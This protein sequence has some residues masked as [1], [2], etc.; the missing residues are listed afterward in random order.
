[1]GEGP[2]D[3]PEEPLLG[4][5]YD[6][7]WDADG[8]DDG[9][10]DEDGD[11]RYEDEAY[12]EEP[13]DEPEPRRSRRGRG[14]L[15]VLIVLA[16][17]VGAGW[18]GGRWAYDEISSRLAPAPDYD[19]PGS[20]TVLYQVRSGASSVQIGRG[21]KAKGVVKSVDAFSQAARENDKSRDIQVGYYQ[22]KKQMKASQALDLLVDPANLVQNLV[23]V[24]EGARVNQIVGTI[25]AKTD[26]SRRAVTSALANPRA[27]GLPAEAKGNP[28][29]FLFPATYTVP[30]K[31]TAVGLIKEMVSKSVAVE[32]DLGVTS[33]GSK[34]GF[35]AEQVLTV[36]SILEYE[37]NTSEDY[38]K[39]ARVLYNRLDKG[40]LLQLDSTVSYI[41]KRKGD[42]FTTAAERASPS[43]YNTYVHKGLPPGPIG[44]PGEET[45][46]AALAPAKGT[47]LFFVPDYENKSTTFSTTLAQHN[48]AVAKLKKYCRTHEEC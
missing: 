12:E 25:V 6:G 1:M 15:P 47:W 39:V 17:L 44:S 29:G 31:Q 16:V 38:P 11:D 9:D 8:D 23:V 37:A 7:D 10:D 22:L 41:S 34:L 36:A 24:P 45:I 5:R 18:F 30:P 42:V 28:E 35:T 4:D 26:I 13:D 46:K 48:S 21:L 27:I 20:G 19:G 14:C 32:K 33:K 2:G 40:M 3:D 43:L